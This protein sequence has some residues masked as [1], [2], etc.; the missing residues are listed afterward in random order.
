[1][2]FDLGFALNTKGLVDQVKKAYK[3]FHPIDQDNTWVTLQTV[4]NQ[5][6]LC[7]GS[8]DYKIPHVGKDKLREQGELPI[9]WR[10]SPEALVVALEFVAE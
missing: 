8:N 10:A 4:L 3:A 9:Q 6:I 5:I 1:M 2:L 7:N